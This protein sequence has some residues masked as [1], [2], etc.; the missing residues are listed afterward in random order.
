MMLQACLGL[1][2]D[3]T[4]SRVLLRSPCLPRSL[5]RVSIR[6]LSLGS[7]GDVDLTLARSGTN[8]AVNVERRTGDLEVIVLS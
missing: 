5:D 1:T 3:A 7:A 8:V 2:V 6:G 4:R